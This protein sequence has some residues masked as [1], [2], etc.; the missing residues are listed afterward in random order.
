[1]D[2][3]VLIKA[4]K[5]KN[6]E[7]AIPIKEAFVNKA[8][9]A[10]LEDGENLS[11]KLVLECIQEAGKLELFEEEAAKPDSQ[12]AADTTP[13]VRPSL[14]ANSVFKILD[15]KVHQV[16]RDLFDGNAEVP[17]PEWSDAVAW[18]KQ[19]Q[20]EGTPQLIDW[21]KRHQLIE[22]VEKLC[23]EASELTGEKM[24]VEKEFPKLDIY[25]EPGSKLSQLDSILVKRWNRKLRVV[26]G[27]VEAAFSETGLPRHLSLLYLLSG[28]RRM[29]GISVRVLEPPQARVVMTR[30]EI[31]R[32]TPSWEDMRA[33]Y[34]Q[35]RTLRGNRK[36]P[37]FTNREVVSSI[38][39]LG[40]VPAKG[41]MKFWQAVADDVNRKE[42]PLLKK[43]LSDKAVRERFH[44]LPEE[45][46][47]SLQ[48]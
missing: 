10:V 2:S 32:L 28:K 29:P 11:N 34:K 26:L 9:V 16:R 7:R 14:L 31:P 47:K 22:R 39:D 46:K 21:E 37:D 44:R 38:L 3:A 42:N 17:F 20:A 5:T 45:W 6:S 4:V 8:L 23:D 15:D 40:G 24:W 41:K 1:M 36:A 30:I 43:I 35:L 25:R 33:A 18:M 13:D 19:Q 27:F 12:R 48:A